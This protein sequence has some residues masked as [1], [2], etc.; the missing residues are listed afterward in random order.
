MSQTIIV[1]DDISIVISDRLLG[2][3]AVVPQKTG[4][5]NKYRRL[6]VMRRNLIA[7]A[8]ALSRESHRHKPFLQVVSANIQTDL[9]SKS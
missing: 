1:T 9:R 2:T 3:L 6:S 4:R 5:R 8:K 7:S